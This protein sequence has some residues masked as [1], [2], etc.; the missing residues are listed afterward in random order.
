[1]NSSPRVLMLN[2][3]F[4]SHLSDNKATLRA[5]SMFPLIST[6]WLGVTTIVAESGTEFAYGVSYLRQGSIL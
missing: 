5:R 3:M 6:P 4:T 1:M 2:A